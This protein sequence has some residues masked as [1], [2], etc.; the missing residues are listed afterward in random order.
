[1][2]GS[3][4]P[5]EERQGTRGEG[6]GHQAC[7]A[8]PALTPVHPSIRMRASGPRSQH[9]TVAWEVA[10]ILSLPPFP[11][12]LPV[13]EK[14]RARGEGEEIP[15]PR[16]GAAGGEG[17]GEELPSLRGGAAGGEGGR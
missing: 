17:E 2:S 10:N 4:L 11:L 12:P 5:V 1:M 9:A 13:E 3:H 16:G 14:K 6:E 8:A 7:S 15:S